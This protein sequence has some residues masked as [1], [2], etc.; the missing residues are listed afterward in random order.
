MD[1]ERLKMLDARKVYKCCLCK[2]TFFGWGNNA[3]PIKNGKCC[4]NCNLKKVG[5]SILKGD[6]EK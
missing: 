3:Q 5:F 2:E 6:E 1:K 4:N